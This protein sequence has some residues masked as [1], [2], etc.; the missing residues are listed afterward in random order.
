[1]AA[2]R[3][4][5]SIQILTSQRRP[6]V[7]KDRFYTRDAKY[8]HTCVNNAEI[9]PVDKEA[10]GYSTMSQSRIKMDA[11]PTQKELA[12]SKRSGENLQASVYNSS[13]RP[14]IE[15]SITGRVSCRST[16]SPSSQSSSH[17]DRADGVHKTS[18]YFV[19]MDPSDPIY[20][21]AEG[22]DE[23]CQEKQQNSALSLPSDTVD[24][25]FT[26]GFLTA[27]MN[28]PSSAQT[29]FSEDPERIYENNPYFVVTDNSD[30][31]YDEAEGNNATYLE[32]LPDTSTFRTTVTSKA[33]VDY[34]LLNVHTGGMASFAWDLASF[35][36]GLEKKSDQPDSGPLTKP[37]A[38]TSYSS[39]DHWKPH[40]PGQMDSSMSHTPTPL[41]DDEEAIYESITSPGEEAMSRDLQHAVNELIKTEES[42]VQDLQFVTSDLQHR[43]EEIPAVDVK[44]LFSNLNEIVSV[45]SAF[46]EELKKTERDELNQLIRIGELFQTFSQDMQ[47]VYCVYCLEYPRALALLDHYKETGVFQQIQDVLH[48]TQ[49]ASKCFDIS[50]FLVMPVQRITKYPLLIQKIVENV[51]PNMESH[52][53]LQRAFDT[54]REVNHNINDF[55]RRKEVAGKY[56]HGEQRTLRDKVSQLNTHT[57]SK[58]TQRISQMFK[59]QAGIVPKREDKEFD[60]LADKFQALATSVTQLKENVVCYMKN[61]EVFLSIEPHTS[62]HEL[63]PGPAQQFQHLFQVLFQNIYPEFKRRLQSLVL[64]PLSNLSDCLKGPKTLIRKRMDKLLDYENLENKY[65]ETGKATWEEE[66]II[67]NYKTIHSMLLSELPR[68]I[69]MSMQWLHRLLLTFLTLQRD[70]AKQALYMADAEAAQLPNYKAPESDFKRWIDDCIS[71]S[72]S[73]LSEFS[74]KFNEEMPAPVVQEHSS[75][76]HQEVHLLLQRHGSEKLYQVMSNVSGS[77]DLDLTLHR[78]QVVAVLQFTDTKGNKNRWLVDVGGSRGYVPSNKLQAYHVVH[79]PNPSSSLLAVKD[80]GEKR[81]H[82]YTSQMCPYPVLQDPTPIFQIVAGYAFNAR[83]NYEVSVKEGQPVTVLEPHDKKG[84]PEWSLVEVNGQRGYM[85][86]SYL[87]RVPVQDT[88][89]WM[90]SS[91]Y[92]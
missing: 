39:S 20:D 71:R 58:K 65:N 30:L 83:S 75:T 26:G 86:S 33:R 66:A 35:A 45:S 29:D 81:R 56:I 62:K 40:A 63:P 12:T 23:K 22:S 59:Q 1:M 49:F 5:L 79:S 51:P 17:D 11:T 80:N 24:Q 72:A 69:T 36:C 9:Y 18:Q 78:G 32:V 14:Y 34:F 31:I 73:Q 47:E 44:N 43:L 8:S 16:C 60:C 61:L 4:K 41:S 38:V 10:P 85:P 64:Q 84:S 70:L 15:S 42:Y 46:L 6:S 52:G 28:S 25:S 3:R 7:F 90:L 67:N 77:R 19:E 53:F 92:T 89:H 48:A 37:N 88:R 87:V 68:C 13:Q 74:K 91:N 55:K 50:F 54:M 82:S 76:F 2:I 27:T 57:L 21:E